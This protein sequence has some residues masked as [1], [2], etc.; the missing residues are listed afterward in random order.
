MVDG[1]TRM[2]DW[3]ALDAGRDLD[4]RIAERLGWTHIESTEYWLDDPHD[5]S[6]VQAWRGIPPRSTGE[7][8]VP[9]YSTDLNAAITLIP[10]DQQFELSNGLE[11]EWEALIGW[12]YDGGADTPALAVCRAWLAYQDANEG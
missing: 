10:S 1:M 11:P 3:R 5:T 7:A 9:C 6:L 12:G 4:R 2:T 8:L